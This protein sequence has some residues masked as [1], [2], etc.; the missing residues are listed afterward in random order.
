MVYNYTISCFVY[1]R[2]LMIIIVEGMDRC[3]KDT[4]IKHIRKHKLKNVKTMMMHCV[5]PPSG[6]PMHWALKHYT[7]LL[8]HITKMSDCGWDI[9]L[10]RSH[11]GED[12]YG[13]IYRNRPAE[14]VYT[15]DAQ[16]FYTRDDV[17][18]VTVVD[19]PECV[20]SREDGDSLSSNIDDI[21]KVRESFIRVHSK[22]Q[23]KNKLLY[24]YTENSTSLK[25]MIR[26]V[27]F[28]ITDKLPD[29]G[30]FN[31]DA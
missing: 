2:K 18:L 21:S 19:S 9:I 20:M 30:Y 14:W 26:G 11:L 3:G 13:P 23:I 29:R 27:D 15:L 24:D 4:L 1:R 7:E 17:M 12:V 22:S 6:A 16:F 8:S 28:Q 10:N 31:G 5:S 25:D